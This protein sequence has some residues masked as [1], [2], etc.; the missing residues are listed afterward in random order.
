[1]ID[2]VEQH[3]GEER[4]EGEKHLLSLY[5]IPGSVNCHLSKLQS[6]SAVGTDVVTIL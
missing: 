4:A 6:F 1:M 2:N 3:G 5:S